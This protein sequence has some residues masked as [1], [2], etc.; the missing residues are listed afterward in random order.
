MFRR[1]DLRR[2]PIILLYAARNN[3]IAVYDTPLEGAQAS[4]SAAST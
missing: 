4:V 1:K 2:A 3:D